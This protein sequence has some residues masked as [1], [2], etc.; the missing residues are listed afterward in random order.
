LA[1]WRLRGFDDA[2][3]AEAVSAEAV[4]C[5]AVFAVLADGDLDAAVLVPLLR[6][7]DLE[8]APFAEVLDDGFAPLAGFSVAPPL[9]VLPRARAVAGAFAAG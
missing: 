9:A 6:V 1:D 2:V 7:E 4:R 5:D 3:F 8:A